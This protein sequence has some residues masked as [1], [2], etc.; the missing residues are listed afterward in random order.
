MSDDEIR[1]LQAQLGEIRRL[2]AQLTV[3][4][5]AQADLREVQADLQGE[6][7]WRISRLHDLKYG[8]PLQYGG[9]ISDGNETQ[10]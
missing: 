8:E 4:N 5:G 3:L 1:Q 7:N 9:K 2:E 6:I 10:C